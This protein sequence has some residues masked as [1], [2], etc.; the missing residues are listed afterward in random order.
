VLGVGTML[1][2]LAFGF[3]HGIDWDHLAALTDITSCEEHPKRSLFLATMYALGHAMIVLA[4]GFGAIVLGTRLPSG[5]D[6]VM[7]RVVGATL[8]ALAGYVFYSIAT[9]GRAFRLRSRWMLLFSLG[10]KIRNTTRRS[11]HDAVITI[12]H[13]HGHSHDHTHD[14]THDRVHALA[15]AASSLPSSSVHTHTHVH[16]GRVPDDPFVTYAPST[17]FAVGMLHGIGAETPTQVLI[18]VTAAGVGGKAS[19][20]L[21]L[22]CFL[23][24]LLASNTV[25]AATGALGFF[26]AARNFKIYAAVSLLTAVFSLVVGTTLV[27]AGGGAMPAIFGG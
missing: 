12:E 1:T 27:L 23:I 3:R 9:K 24:G 26:G 16:A 5:V 8:I 14:H 18:F 11:R 22:A 13:E 7:E 10:H 6:S 15:H 25:V 19:G 4:L 20:V 2:A 17:A 21:I